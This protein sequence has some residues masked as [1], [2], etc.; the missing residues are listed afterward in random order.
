MYWLSKKG[1]R[2]YREI[3]RYISMY[4]VHKEML[5]SIVK[6]DLEIIGIDTEEIKNIL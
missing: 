1:I 3:A 2:N 5:I 4:H 6:R